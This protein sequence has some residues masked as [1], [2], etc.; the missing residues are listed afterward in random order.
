MRSIRH[1][2]DF[3]FNFGDIDH[4]DGVPRAA[5]QE[6][7]VRTLAEALLA[8]NALDGINL[9][10]PERRIVLVRHPEHAI[11]H[12]TVLHAGRRPRAAGTALRNN[13]KFLRLLLACGGDTLG[14]GLLLQLVR[15]HS[16]GFDNV[17]CVSHFL[18]FYPQCQAFVSVVFAAS[19]PLATMPEQSGSNHTDKGLTLGVESQEMA[20]APDVVKAPGMVPDELKQEPRSKG[21]STARKKKPKELAVIT[22]CCTGC[23]GSP[24]C[25][26]YCPVEDCM[27]WV[28]DEDN[29]PFGRIQIDPLQCIGCKKCL[30]KGPDGCFL[31]GCPW[32]AIVMVDIAEVEKEVGPMSY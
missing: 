29:P 13:G 8:P 7:A 11:F 30:S 31:D 22:E 28:P 25:V 14:A 26:E 5:I 20:N 2:A 24:A 10:A 9:D 3:F 27:F 12:R 32:D 15:H 18:C 1:W 17:G 6:A 23:A 4:D 19:P 21:V 16:R